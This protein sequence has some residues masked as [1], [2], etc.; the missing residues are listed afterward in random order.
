[1]CGNNSSKKTIFHR[2]NLYLNIEKFFFGDDIFEF[3]IVRDCFQDVTSSVS[4]S[5]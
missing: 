4:A 5:P 2:V 3:S 1:M